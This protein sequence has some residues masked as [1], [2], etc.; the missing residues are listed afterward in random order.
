MKYSVLDTS[1]ESFDK[2]GYNI[3]FVL[4]KYCE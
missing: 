3:Y 2:V 4:L 1:Q